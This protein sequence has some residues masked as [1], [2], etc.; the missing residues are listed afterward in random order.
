MARRSEELVERGCVHT[1]AK[2]VNGRCRSGGNP[3]PLFPSHIVE[4]VCIAALAVISL[5]EWRKR[6]GAQ[7]SRELWKFDFQIR[8]LLRA[9]AVW[10]HCYLV[11]EWYLSC[12]SL[13]HPFSHSQGDIGQCTH[14]P[15]M[16]D[17]AGPLNEK[18]KQQTMSCIEAKLILPP[19]GSGNE[20]EEEEVNKI[21]TPVP[22]PQVAMQ[23]V[24]VVKSI[25]KGNFF[26]EK[27]YK[28]DRDS[29]AL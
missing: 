7:S 19:T 4:F 8:A 26:R 9:E 27:M 2:I 23:V 5:A 6:S 3:I 1:E 10:Y 11:L 20:E 25:Y 22:A 29:E 13:T 12:S 24:K 15:S 16:Q 17:R 28:S 21:N 14:H 18:R